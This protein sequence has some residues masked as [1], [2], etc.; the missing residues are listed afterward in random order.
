MVQ[1]WLIRNTANQKR[2]GAGEEKGISQEII[3]DIV[4]YLY[5]RSIS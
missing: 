4:K 3:G 5:H 2:K 1:R